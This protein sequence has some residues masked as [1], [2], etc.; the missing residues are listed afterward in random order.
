MKKTLIAVY[1]TLL[2][3]FGNHRLIKN[4]EYLGTFNSKPI[5]NLHDLGGFPGL[6][7]GGKTSVKMEVYAVNEEEAYY[8]DCLE[9]YTPGG[10]NTFYDK[11]T[12]STPFGDAGVY[13]YVRSLEGVPLVESG[14]YYLHKKGKVSEEHM[15]LTTI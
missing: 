10:N 5:Y 2:A 3:G 1:G 9:G 8:V 4:A 15:D 11:E 7:H 6:K 12:I 13:I 14:D